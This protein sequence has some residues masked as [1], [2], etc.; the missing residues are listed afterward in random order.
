M[1]HVCYLCDPNNPHKLF[2]YEGGL[3]FLRIPKKFVG[4]PGRAHGGMSIASLMCPALRSASENGIV[5][6]IVRTV[7]GRLH[8][9]VPLDTPMSAEVSANNDGYGVVVSVGDS[10]AITGAVTIEHRFVEVG[11]AIQEAPESLRMPLSDVVSVA[12]VSLS[13]PTLR[14]QFLENCVAAGYHSPRNVCFGCAETPDALQLFNR[15]APNGNLWTRWQTEPCFIDRPGRLAFAMAAAALDCSNLWVL[16][17]DSIERYFPGGKLFITGSFTVHFLRV[18][19]IY[20]LNDYRVVARHL[21][22]EGRKGFTMSALLDDQGVPYA[23]AESTAIL[24][25]TPSEL[26][27]ET[28]EHFR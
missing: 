23:I 10:I 11:D 17:R 2:T 12:D 16:N 5:D 4:P 14:E 9:P 18:L 13:G 7:S 21:Y 20:M 26:A 1:E 27:L 25:D 19:P 15:V 24:I 22:T 3:T 6:P 8:M 28:L